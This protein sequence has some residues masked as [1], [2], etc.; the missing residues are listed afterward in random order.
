MRGKKKGATSFVMVNLGEL[1]RLLKPEAKIMVSRRFAE[2][3]E[4]EC[5]NIDASY[6]NYSFLTSQID[7]A[8]QQEKKQKESK[9]SLPKKLKIDF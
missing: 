7:I 6:K 4:M 5:Q 1:N 8:A 9:D 3:L 2:T